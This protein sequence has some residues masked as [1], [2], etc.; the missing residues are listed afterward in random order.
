LFAVEADRLLRDGT[1]VP[2]ADQ[3]AQADAALRH[4]SAEVGQ[5]FDDLRAQIGPDP[6]PRA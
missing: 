6:A 3:L 4:R 5:A 2:S 1:Q